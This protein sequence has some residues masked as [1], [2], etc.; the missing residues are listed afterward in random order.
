ML[1]PH[2]VW[3]TEASQWEVSVYSPTK[4]LTST[5]SEAF[6][7]AATFNDR[8][9][10]QSRCQDAWQRRIDTGHDVRA[11]RGWQKYY[12]VEA[13]SRKLPST[14]VGTSQTDS[15]WPSDV[16]EYIDAVQPVN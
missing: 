8:F 5:T 13:T 15:G 6:L 1:P 11:W 2:E 4:R 3:V 9:A 14:A 7:S 10:S 12:Q 16:S